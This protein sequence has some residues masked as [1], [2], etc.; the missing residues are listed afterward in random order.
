MIIQ[1]YNI[2]RWLYSSSGIICMHVV[3]SSVDEDS[4]VG[5]DGPYLDTSAFFSIRV[6]GEKLTQIMPT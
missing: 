3:C 1:L 5:R 4:P 6:L 2:Y